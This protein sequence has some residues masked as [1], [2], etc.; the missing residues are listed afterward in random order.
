MKT[1]QIAFKQLR[2]ID[3]PLM[4]KWLNTPHVRQWYRIYAKKSPS[5]DEV[6]RKYLPRINGDDPTSCYVIVYDSMPIG[7]VQSYKLDDYPSEKEV[8]NLN[9]CCVGIDIFIGEEDY[10]HQGLGSTIIKRFLQ[11]IVFIKYDVDCCIVDPIIRNEVAI[12]AYHKAGFKYVK[13]FWNQ[14]EGEYGYIM[15]INRDEIESKK[16]SIKLD[17]RDDLSG[18]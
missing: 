15:S 18:V 7:M 8:F 2:Q 12:K 6:R 3:L 9:Q 10:I 14:Q 13:T 1:G 16:D 11:Q 4:H 5:Q 17:T